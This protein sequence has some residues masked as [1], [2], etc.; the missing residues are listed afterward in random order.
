MRGILH[1]FLFVCGAVLVILRLYPAHDGGWIS[2]L[3][4]DN[5]IHAKMEAASLRVIQFLGLSFPAY[6]SFMYT[7]TSLGHAFAILSQAVA[8]ALTFWIIT[9]WI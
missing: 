8:I 6:N 2:Q 4:L 1:K 3:F 9:R 7:L 5:M